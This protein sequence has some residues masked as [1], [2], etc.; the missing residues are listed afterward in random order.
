MEKMSQYIVKILRN[1]KTI[2][3]EVHYFFFDELIQF[4]SENIKF[5]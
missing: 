4:Y 2:L 1:N 5:P 3:Y